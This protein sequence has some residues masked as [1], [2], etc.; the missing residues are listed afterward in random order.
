MIEE[1]ELIEEVWSIKKIIIG[2]ASIATVAGGG[3]AVK[4]FV[5]DKN[6]QEKPSVVQE[7]SK[8]VEGAQTQQIEV[9][10]IKENIQEKL[11][12][13]RSE[14]TNLNAA[15]VASSSPQVQKILQDLKGLEN[16]PKDQAK[17]MCQQ[18]CNGL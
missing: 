8:A 2:I 11:N 5:L 13:L 7:S 6:I 12:S 14:V 10:E 18:I 3:Y 9:E 1:G 17:N 16:Y 15:E 4:E